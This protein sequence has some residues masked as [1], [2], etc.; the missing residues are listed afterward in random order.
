M[1]ILNRFTELRTDIADWR[2]DLHANPE[3]GF[4]VHRTAEL[5]AEKLKAFGVDEVVTGIGTTGVIGV[6]KGKQTNPARVVGMRADM[7]ALPVV[8]TTGLPYASKIEGRMHAC[9]HDGHT[10]ML[11]GAAKYLS[12]TRDFNGTSVVIFQPAEEDAC[13][14][15]AMIDDGMME[16]FGIQEV[17]GMHNLPGVPVGKFVIRPGPFLAASDWFTIEIEGRGGHAAFPNACIDPT[18]IGTQMV[19]A[20]QLVVSRAIAPVDSAVVSITL[21]HTGG[22]SFNVIPQ[23]LHMK[24]TVR[25]LDAGVQGLIEEQMN[26]IVDHTAKAFGARAVL[27]YQ[28]GIPVTRNTERETSFA[29]DI[30]AEVVGEQHVDRNWPPLLGGEDFSYMLNARPGAFIFLGNGNTAGLHHP[31]FDFNDEAISFGCSYWARLAERAMPAD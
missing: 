9:G 14:A 20:L 10:A 17:Y 16:R 2:R 1:T 23:T 7:D 28:R 31:Q 11:L 25:T 13:G 26:H 3:L 21:F 18:V 22:D 24:G 15:R 19:N 30:A 5:V 8:E 29:A 6:I 27:N 4:N 12:E